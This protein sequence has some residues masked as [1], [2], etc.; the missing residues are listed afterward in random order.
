MDIELTSSADNSKYLIHAKTEIAYILRGIMQKNELVTA[1][2]HQGNDFLLTSIIAVEP[3][4]DVLLLDFGA[5]DETN[6]KM[7]ASSKVIFVTTQEKVKI[8]FA[9]NSI[10]ATTFNQRDAFKLKLPTELLK[11]QRREY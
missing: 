1:Y 11:L 4:E 6:K 9:E 10:E 7:L 8:Q 3:D 5:N 2:F